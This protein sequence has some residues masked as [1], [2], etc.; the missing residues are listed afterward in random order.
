MIVGKAQTELYSL[1]AWESTV[2]SSCVKKAKVITMVPQRASGQVQVVAM[3]PGGAD[4][5]EEARINEVV[6]K[7]FRLVAEEKQIVFAGSFVD[8]IGK[9][10]PWVWKSLIQCF[11]GMVADVSGVDV[12]HQIKSMRNAFI[13]G[14][15]PHGGF[16]WCDASLLL[17]VLPLKC[18][19]TAGRDL[20]SD[21][22]EQD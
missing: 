12:Y 15:P 9:E 2:A 3:R 22:E 7:A 6:Q 17:K 20:Y 1:E 16:V 5:E 18:V 11:R 13:S 21:T 10:Q 19:Q 4:A 14:A 8:G